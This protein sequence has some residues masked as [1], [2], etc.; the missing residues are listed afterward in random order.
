MALSFMPVLFKFQEEKY[1]MDLFLAAMSNSSS[2][3][4]T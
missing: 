4:V 2:D 3:Y 1:V